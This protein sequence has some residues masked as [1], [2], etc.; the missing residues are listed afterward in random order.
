M[1]EEKLEGRFAVPRAHRSTSDWVLAPPP[2]SP[3]AGAPDC[4]VRIRSSISPT[5]LS[6]MSLIGAV[7]GSRL[8]QRL[9]RCPLMSGH[10]RVVL[11]RAESSSRQPMSPPDHQSTVTV[12]LAVS[13]V[14]VV[15]RWHRGW[16]F[17]NRASCT[18]RGE[19]Q[20]A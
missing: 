19:D 4:K 6:W 1:S 17:T 20:R 16:T 3:V 12:L 15:P 11:N 13:A 8:W 18:R 5:M 14:P 7:T 2:S 9:V 10:S